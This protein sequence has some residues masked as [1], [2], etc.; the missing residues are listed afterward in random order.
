MDVL[1]I[2][3]VYMAILVFGITGG[4]LLINH[5]IKEPFYRFFYGAIFFCAMIYLVAKLMPHESENEYDAC[6]NSNINK[7]D[8]EY[9]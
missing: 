9:R 6:G 3:N 5:F 7:K 4:I 1:E 8:W 2:A